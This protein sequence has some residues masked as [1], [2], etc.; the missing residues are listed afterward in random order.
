MIGLRS[1]TLKQ[2]TRNSPTAMHNIPN[3]CAE[4]GGCVLFSALAT[5]YVPAATK[6]TGNGAKYNDWH[7]GLFEHRVFSVV[8]LDP[9]TRLGMIV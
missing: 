5:I 4:N 3:A 2:I 9:N 6:P 1:N 8:R 7:Y